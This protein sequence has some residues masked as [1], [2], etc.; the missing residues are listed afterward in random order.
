MTFS[1]SMVAVLPAA[2]VAAVLVMVLVRVA[3]STVQRS[4]RFTQRVLIVGT[5]P[6]ARELADEIASRRDR[7]YR[8]AIVVEGH[9]AEDAV[10]VRCP[11]VGSVRELSA[12]LRRLQ[13]DRIVVALSERRGRSIMRVLLEAR[14]GGLL[15]ED[16]VELYERLTG[17]IAIDNLSPSSLVFAKGFRR[18]RAR[19]VWRRI[20]G[21]AVAAVSLIAL[22]PLLVLIAAAIAL[23]SRGSVLFEQDRM[24]VSGR[25]FRVM[26]FRTMHPISSAPSEWEADNAHRITNVGRWLRRMRLDEL[27]QLVN[28]LRGEMELVGP[29]PQPMRNAELF[30]REIPYY[31]LRASVT[32][33]ITGWAQVRYG[34]A[35]DLDGEIEKMR[36]DLYYIK[37]QSLWFDL[38]IAVAT[39][40]ALVSGPRSAQRHGR[41]AVRRPMAGEERDA[42]LRHVLQ[43]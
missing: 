35:N 31:W 5:S 40:G 15:V 13:P 25:A 9:A 23:D 8:V 29:R 18:S 28:V 7:R 42:R 11:I 24:G 4:R 10:G 37:H 6:L 14:A 27:P 16:G 19:R 41:H 43:L 30:A 26:K 3:S 22:A 17:K 34:Y 1:V 32:P 21:T 36:Y 38:K 12:V 39:V 2:I 20:V 33:G